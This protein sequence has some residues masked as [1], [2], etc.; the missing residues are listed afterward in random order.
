MRF[1][2]QFTKPAQPP[3]RPGRGVARGK[4]NFSLC[5]EADRR[6]LAAC[7]T[8]QLQLMTK[9]VLDLHAYATLSLHTVAYPVSFIRFASVYRPPTHKSVTPCSS[10]TRFLSRVRTI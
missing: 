10:E 6:A 4:A 9:H 8:G 7:P 1:R 3:T 2:F 5:H